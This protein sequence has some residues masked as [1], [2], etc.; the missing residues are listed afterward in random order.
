[1]KQC[2]AVCRTAA[3]PEVPPRQQ[4]SLTADRHR[5]PRV[6]PPTLHARRSTAIPKAHTD[7]H[8]FLGWEGW[9]QGRSWSVVCA[10]EH[11]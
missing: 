4:P 6:T 8:F 5:T 10:Q 2:Q 3:L 1:M 9:N 7:I 11:H